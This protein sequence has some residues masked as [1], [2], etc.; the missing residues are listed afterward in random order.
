M[1]KT[2]GCSAVTVRYQVYAYELT[3][4]T[5]HLDLTHAYCNGAALFLYVP[6][7]EREPYTLTV[8]PLHPNWRIATSLRPLSSPSPED[9]S[10]GQ[11]FFAE[12]YDE[13]ADSPVEVGLH[14]CARLQWKGSRTTPWSGERAP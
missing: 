7:R 1:I 14:S 8:I 3:V 11:S 12:D 2:P 9:P 4:R 5:N 6:G 13:L 10:A